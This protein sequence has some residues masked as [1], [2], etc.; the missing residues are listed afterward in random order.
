MER[1]KLTTLRRDLFRVVDRVLESGVPVAIDRNGRTLLLVP[2]EPASR[3]A[4][5]PRRKLIRGDPLALVNAKVGT[6]REPRKLR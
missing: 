4:R 3:L 5:L 6:W 2:Q 1:V